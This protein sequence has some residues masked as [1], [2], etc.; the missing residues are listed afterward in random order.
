MRSKSVH[1][2]K[3]GWVCRSSGVGGGNRSVKQDARQ[4]R[5]TETDL[6]TVQLPDTL[7]PTQVRKLS[8]CPLLQPSSHNLWS[9]GQIDS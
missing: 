9:I 5:N 6:I 1:A 8:E 4:G 7:P 2:A 3:W